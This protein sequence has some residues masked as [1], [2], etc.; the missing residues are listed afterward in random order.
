ITFYRPIDSE[1]L[2]YISL[3]NHCITYGLEPEPLERFSTGSFY[4]DGYRQNDRGGF[5]IG[6]VAHAH[7]GYTDERPALLSP[8]ILHPDTLCCALVS[9]AGIQGDSV[10]CCRVCNHP[11]VPIDARLRRRPC[12]DGAAHDDLPLGLRGRDALF[13]GISSGCLPVQA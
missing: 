9:E 10:P 1:S 6:G 13:S 11:G 2:I 12:D 7:G 8:D 3:N 4:R 5:V